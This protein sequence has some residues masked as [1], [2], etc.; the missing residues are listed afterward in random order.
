MLTDGVKSQSK[1]EEI[2]TLDVAELLAEACGVGA[3][4]AVAAE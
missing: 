2:Q 1:E 3:A 4:P